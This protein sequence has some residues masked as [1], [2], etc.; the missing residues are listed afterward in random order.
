MAETSAI[1]WCD[2]TVNFWWGCTKVG[3]GCDN[4][5]AEEWNNFRG[6]KLWGAGAPRREIK[7]AVALIQK[8]QRD[9]VRFFDQHGRKRRV[10]MQSM[11]DTFDNEVDD[12]LRQRLFD[13]AK[14]A[15]RL[16][17][18]LLTKRIPNVE[19]MVPLSWR[20]GHWPQHVGLMVTIVNQTEANRDIVRLLELKKRL[21]IPWVG[22]SI[23][24]MLE[25]IRLR[26]LQ[27]G[28]GIYL[29]AITGCHGKVEKFGS[30]NRALK[31]ASKGTRTPVALPERLPTLDLVIVG[32]ESGKNAR[33]MHPH[34]A[35]TIYRDCTSIASRTAFLFKQWGEWMPESDV[36]PGMSRRGLE[37]IEL[38]RNPS[39][40]ATVHMDIMRMYRAGKHRS[41][42]L[43]NGR[44]H[45]NFPEALR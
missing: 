23:E 12:A 18:M 35:E 14:A 10:F 38:N 16:N 42:R 34:W 28:G 45:I 1:E 2:A 26:Q 43:L 31:A 37:A 29:D 33:P 36:P 9:A 19:K 5:Y 4:C 30:W 8:L 21:G 15:D 6:N 20:D 7:G 3:P 25:L 17:V 32:G 13:C 11:S 24:P 44:E 22:V 41:G 39:A 27:L 40:F